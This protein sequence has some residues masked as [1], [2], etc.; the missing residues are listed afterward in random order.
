M[1]EKGLIRHEELERSILRLRGHSV[2]LDSDLARIYGVS[3]K[4]LNQAVRRNVERFP[5]D[6][7]FQLSTVEADRL[8]SQS[9]TLKGSRGRHRKYLP[10]AFTEHGV[11]MLATVL[12]SDR[13]VHVS[14]EIVRAFIRLRRALE[15]HG[16]L[17]KKLDALEKKYD[18]Q[19]ADVSPSNRTFSPASPVNP[20][21][22]ILI[23]RGIARVLLRGR[24]TG[25]SQFAD[26]RDHP[27]AFRQSADRAPIAVRTRQAYFGLLLEP[28]TTPTT[29]R[30]IKHPHGTTIP[31]RP[32][33]LRQRHAARC[34]AAGPA[35][36]GRRRATVRPPRPAARRA[37]MPCLPW[38]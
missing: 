15:P 14:V 26:H 18:S 34:G 12:R 21:V 35:T 13:A 25:V 17:A 28:L 36:P 4:A 33:D 37:E 6:F 24:W 5:E 19:F 23:E 7:M 11:A 8:R 2:M 30:N 38:Q 29:P 1:P 31:C 27:P 20:V 9:V 16:E 32:C 3:T 22:Q 10:H